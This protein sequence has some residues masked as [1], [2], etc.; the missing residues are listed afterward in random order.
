MS[1]KAKVG[2]AAKKAP[3][4]VFI[5]YA[6]RDESFKNELT[7]HAGGFGKPKSDQHLAGPSN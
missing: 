3:L 5:S 2:A 4:K 6:H 1:P 7:N